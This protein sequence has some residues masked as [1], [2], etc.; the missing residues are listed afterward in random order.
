MVGDYLH[1][2]TSLEGA[3]NYIFVSP[4]VRTNDIT[5]WIWALCDAD[6]YQWS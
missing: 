3:G 4:F 6:T 2:A 5:N 1:V